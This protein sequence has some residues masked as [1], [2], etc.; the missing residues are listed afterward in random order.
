MGRKSSLLLAKAAANRYGQR[1]TRQSTSPGLTLEELLA[2]S[3]S[4][5]K[6]LFKPSR[7]KAVYGGRAG[8]KSHSLAELML[9]RMILDPDLQCVC[10]RRYRSSLTN[11]VLLLLKNKVA[12]RGWDKYFEVQA[13]QIKRRGERGFIAFIGMQDHNA[14]TIKGYEGFGIGWVEE[15][16][17]IDQFSM[18]LLIPT[19]RKEG[20]ETWFSW[21]PDQPSDPVDAFFRGSS[22]PANAII[23]AVSFKDNPFLSETSKEDEQR[24]LLADPEKHDW[25]WLGGYNV[26]SDAV[27]FAGR[28]RV[29]EV[30]TT[31]WDGPYYGADWGF[32]ND[33][34]A[35]VEAWVSGSQIYV[36]RESY[37]YRLES[38]RIAARWSRDMPGIER[39]TNRADNSRPETISMVRRSYPRLTACE[40]WPGCVEDG[41][42]WLR[43][44]EILVNPSCVNM[45]VELKRYRYKQNRGGDVMAQI[46]DK[47]NHCID[48]L[49]YALEPLIKNRGKAYGESRAHW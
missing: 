24:D 23:K 21:N 40:K 48:S 46:V 5:T 13:T 44:F 14:T 32:A 34:T 18:D 3:P 7:F 45:Q 22:P 17:E 38:D 49:R 11:S 1:Q 28:W 20:A 39:A 30:A 9:A 12:E 36:S 43:G 26:K 31:G 47:D 16:T 33:P 15:A 10:I 42:D 2:H 25:I 41:I 4:W 19:L 29:A 8:A 37:A 27:V 35:L 6:D